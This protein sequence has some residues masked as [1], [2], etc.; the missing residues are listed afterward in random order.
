MN[1]KCHR[2]EAEDAE[3]RR[4][5]DLDSREQVSFVGQRLLKVAPL[6]SG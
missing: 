5:L 1:S 4:H 2:S 6:L 3:D